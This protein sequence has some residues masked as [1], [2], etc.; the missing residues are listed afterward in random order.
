MVIDPPELPFTSLSPPLL[1]P[2]GNH[3]PE[4]EF[5]HSHVCFYIITYVSRN[6]AILLQFALYIQSCV[7]DLS[8]WIN[9]VSSIH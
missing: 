7:Q 4:F 5:Y 3:C 2:K 9:V 6:K 8:I 1:I